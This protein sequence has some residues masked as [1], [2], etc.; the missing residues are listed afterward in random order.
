MSLYGLNRRIINTSGDWFLS[1]RKPTRIF[2]FSFQDSR[3]IWLNVTQLTGSFLSVAAR[4]LAGH[5][6]VI[7]G[8]DLPRE[9]ISIQREELETPKASLGSQFRSIVGTID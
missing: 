5:V 2:K 9:T 4:Y 3:S 7:R 8:T 1:N 6:V